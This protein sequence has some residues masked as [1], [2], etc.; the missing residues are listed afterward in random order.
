MYKQHDFG[1]PDVIQKLYN[2]KNK[3]SFLVAYDAFRNRAGATEP[4]FRRGNRTQVTSYDGWL[5]AI[6]GDKFNANR[7][8][9]VQPASFFPTQIA[10]T[11]A[12]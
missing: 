12:T 4:A 5:G 6:G 3:T 2:S 7:D 1:G 10:N 8:R 11:L 9:S